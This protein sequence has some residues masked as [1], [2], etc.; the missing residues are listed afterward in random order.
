M[1]P[2][3]WATLIPAITAL[4]TSVAGYL[5]ARTAHDLAKTHVQWHGQQNSNPPS[6]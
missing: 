2:E 1:T 4:L 3:L 6:A 5:K